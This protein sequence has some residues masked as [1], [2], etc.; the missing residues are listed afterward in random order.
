MDIR[1]ATQFA[2]GGGHRK[3]EDADDGHPGQPWTPTDEPHPD[4]STP[5]GDGTHKK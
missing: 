5:P 1:S 2:Q 3:D 4:G